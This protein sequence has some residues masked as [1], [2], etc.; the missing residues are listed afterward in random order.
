MNNEELIQQLQWIEEELKNVL[1]KVNYC[2]SAEGQVMFLEGAVQGA[3]L[4][5]EALRINA[6]EK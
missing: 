4:R 6:I 3:Q 1:A 2:E 5:I